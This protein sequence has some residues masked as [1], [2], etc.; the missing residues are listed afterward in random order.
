MQSNR[1]ASAARGL[2]LVL[3]VLAFLA[4]AVPSG[5]GTE[6]GSAVLGKVTYRAYCGSCHGDTGKGD[7][8]LAASLPGPRPTD[9]TQLAKANGGTFP[10]DA[11]RE[12]IDGRTP[13]EGHPRG[14]MPEWGEVFAT[15]DPLGG[16]ANVER[17]VGD[18][19]AYV[20]TWQAKAE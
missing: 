2:G 8:T 17:K 3:V 7:G 18:V 16:E 20:A 12:A 19:V 6:D 14:E 13:R 11:V 9:L 4:A 5:A 1:W 15:I 10:A